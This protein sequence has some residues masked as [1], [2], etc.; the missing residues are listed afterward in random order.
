MP[1]PPSAPTDP[2]DYVLRRRSRS[3]LDMVKTAL[4]TDNLVLA[5][6]PVVYAEN[7]DRAAFHEGLIRLIDENGEIIPVYKKRIL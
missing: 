7:T 4:E 3:V 5:F 1:Q 2:L 6:Q